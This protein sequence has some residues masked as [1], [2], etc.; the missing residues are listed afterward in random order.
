[1]PNHAKGNKKGRFIRNDT[2]K[3]NT[4]TR[5]NGG[6]IIHNKSVPAAVPSWQHS[7]TAILGSPRWVSGSAVLLQ[8]I[9]QLP[10]CW[11]CAIGTVQ[12]KDGPLSCVVDGLRLFTLLC[13]RSSCLLL[14]L[15]GLGS[16]RALCLDKALELEVWLHHLILHC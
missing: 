12:L 2:S 1:M 5:T 7:L 16:S 13:R 15:F 11:Y 14:R 6:A 8:Y 10:T 3:P 4:N 9:R